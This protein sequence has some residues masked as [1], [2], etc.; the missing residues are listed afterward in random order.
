MN[1]LCENKRQL[2]F[3]ILR[4]IAMCMI[5]TMHYIVKGID[6]PKLSVDM[7]LS[8]M[9]WW[10]IYAFSVGA[11]NIYVLISGYFSVTSDR[12]KVRRIFDI[13]LDKHTRN[14]RFGAF[15]PHI[16]EYEA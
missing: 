16:C 9:I 11:V 7:S 3:E 6:T 15:I 4:I 10:L 5:I 8:N 14:Y 2:N 1:D 13:I 12:L